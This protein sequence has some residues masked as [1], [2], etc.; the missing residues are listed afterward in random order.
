MQRAIPVPPRAEPE[1]EETEHD[2]QGAD[3]F[4]QIA[5]FLPSWLSSFVFHLMM[6]LM[7]ALLVFGNGAGR[8]NGVGIDIQAG[9]GGDDLSNGGSPL[10]EA[11]ETPSELSEPVEELSDVP[12]ADAL[13]PDV[14][15][16]IPDIKM[17]E[18]APTP[19]LAALGATGGGGIGGGEGE[20]EGDGEGI[21][22]G[23]MGLGIS[24]VRTEVFGLRAE[25]GRFVYVFDRS[26][27]MNSVLTF[28]SEGE[29]VFS[30]TPLDAAKAE[31]KRSLQDLQQGNEFG[32]VFYNHSPWVFTIGRR[33]N[34]MLV[35]TPGNKRKALQFIDSM[36]GFG[37]TAH[38]KPLEIAL[39]MKPDVIFLLTDGER[40]DDLMKDELE[41]LKRLN[42]HNTQINVI[43]FCYQEMDGGSLVELAEQHHGKH[44]FFNIAKLG[45]KGPGDLPPPGAK[46]GDAPD[47][48]SGPVAGIGDALPPGVVAKDLQPLP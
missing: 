40:K 14:T 4:R 26:E 42:E 20:G 2:D 9:N 11:V 37:K 1:V 13:V 30:I 7:L 24:P 32:I 36:Y 45:P 15:E 43:Q 10:Q 8:G 16:D 47:Q 23:G 35:A 46:P 19:S 6:V 41:K 21:A 3:L 48:G 28:S 33:N 5:E 39:K 44:V 29:A 38:M 27:S 25:G 34:S 31:L 22:R 12:S 17:N 18:L